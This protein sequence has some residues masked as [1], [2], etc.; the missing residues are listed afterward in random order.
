M[1]AQTLT[2]TI[3]RKIGQNRGKPRLWIEGAHL[4]AAGFKPGDMFA[5]NIVGDTF[6]MVRCDAPSLP[7]DKRPRK[8]S[9]KGEK[10]IMDISGAGLGA[11]GNAASVTL[12]YLP[13]SGVI[14]GEAGA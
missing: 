5:F 8:V 6:A 12:R 9:G 7:S 4:T 11:I 2:V 3:T 1:N 10:P 13:G 14:T